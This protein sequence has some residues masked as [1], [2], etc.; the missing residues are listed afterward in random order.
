MLLRN[1]RKDNT[2]GGGVA[3]YCREVL[4]PKI[5]FRSENV[6][7]VESLFIEVGDAHTKCFVA[8]VYNPNRTNDLTDL[9]RNCQNLV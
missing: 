2:R 9:F 7:E 6:S 5:I 1:D 4:N 8:C 3:I